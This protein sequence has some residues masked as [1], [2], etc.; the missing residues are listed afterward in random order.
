MMQDQGWKQ[1]SPNTASNETLPVIY[2]LTCTKLQ[3]N[4]RE[5]K[6]LSS[7]LRWIHNRNT[8]LL[9]ESHGYFSSAIQIISELSF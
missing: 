4:L 6:I 8:V 9:W 1:P 3:L 2:T 7:S 5:A